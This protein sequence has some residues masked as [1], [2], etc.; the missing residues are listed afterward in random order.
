MRRRGPPHPAPESPH[1]SRTKHPS[2]D[3][4]AHPHN[5]T[6]S[7]SSN[8]S[9]SQQTRKPSWHCHNWQT[10]YVVFQA[11]SHLHPI[12]MAPPANST[13]SVPQPQFPTHNAPRVWVISAGDSPIGISVARQ[14]L[15]HGDCI[16][17]G[18]MPAEVEGDGI[19]SAPFKAFLA[20]VGRNA[21]K[22]WMERLRVFTLDVRCGSS[23]LLLFRH[24][25]HDIEQISSSYV[26]WIR[27]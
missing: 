22:G 8:S 14:A 23:S 2:L 20:E 24:W 15:E 5:F 27:G 11:C 3:F 12:T 21:S 1:D 17:T 19:R 25:R 26:Q 18:V 9:T 4:L 13:P 6:R 7:T 16:A 10:D